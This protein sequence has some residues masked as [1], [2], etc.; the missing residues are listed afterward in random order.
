MQTGGDVHSEVKIHLLRQ[1]RR[2]RTP[3]DNGRKQLVHDLGAELNI[4]VF[5][6]GAEPGV[7]IAGIL[8]VNTDDV[9]RQLVKAVIAL[10]DPGQGPVA[11]LAVDPDDKLVL[12]VEMIIEGLQRQPALFHDLLDGDALQRLLLC[13]GEQRLRE[14]FL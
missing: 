5:H 6:A 12:I 9:L 4:A 13:E 10:L 3:A 14:D 11:H 7:D 8:H 1:L 2:P